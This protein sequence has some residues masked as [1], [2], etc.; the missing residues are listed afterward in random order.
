[1]PNEG[2]RLLRGKYYRDYSKYLCLDCIQGE[3]PRCIDNTQM[4]IISRFLC[5][6]PNDENI[7]P[8]RKGLY[9]V[10]DTDKMNMTNCISC[11]QYL[12]NLPSSVLLLKPEHNEEV[13][14]PN[15]ISEKNMCCVAEAILWVINQRTDIGPQHC[16]KRNYKENWYYLL[17]LSPKVFVEGMFNIFYTFQCDISKDDAIRDYLCKQILQDF[18]SITSILN[19]HNL[20][21]SIQ[22]KVAEEFKN[23]YPYKN[24]LIVR[25]YYNDSSY[26]H[27]FGLKYNEQLTLTDQSILKQLFWL[28][29]HIEKSC[30]L[31]MSLWDDLSDLQKI[32]NAFELLLQAIELYPNQKELYPSDIPIDYND[33]ERIKSYIPDKINDLRTQINDAVYRPCLWNIES[34]NTQ[35]DAS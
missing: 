18:T 28:Q 3:T 17:L 8:I 15:D 23:I 2:S 22:C 12:D 29:K 32:C 13:C 34:Q 14:L 31:Y 27:F 24:K 10:I 25:T 4:S 33:M 19:D 11:D 9:W 6:N 21:H 26:Q 16:I 20:F 5:T 30:K 1:M 35:E 7:L